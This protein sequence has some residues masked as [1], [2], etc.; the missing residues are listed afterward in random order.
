[1]ENGQSRFD[2]IKTYLFLEDD[3]DEL[4]W[5]DEKIE[6]IC[7]DIVNTMLQLEIMEEDDLQECGGFIDYS[8]TACDVA[9][10]LSDREKHQ[11][12][13]TWKTNHEPSI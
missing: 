3:I 8:S 11:I 4:G 6:E 10:Y 5:S 2:E 1:M 7:K 9:E 13:S 12:L